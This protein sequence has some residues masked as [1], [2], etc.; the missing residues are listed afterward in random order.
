MTESSVAPQTDKI[1]HLDPDGGFN[2]TIDVC[3]NTR[4][5]GKPDKKDHALGEYNWKR[6]TIT[7]RRVMD[8]VAKGYGITAALGDAIKVSKSGK[9][10]GIHRDRSNFVS[11]QLAGVDFDAGTSFEDVLDYPLARNAGSFLY[12]TA[13]HTPEAPRCRLILCLEH[14]I[15]EPERAT[16]LLLALIHH[17]GAQMPDKGTHDCVRVW[18]GT[19]P[20]N[21]TYWIGEMLTMSQVDAL[22]AEYRAAGGIRTK[23]TQR[24]SNATAS[25]VAAAPATVAKARGWL[26]RLKPERADEYRDWLHVGMALQS[27]CGNA[28]LTLWEKWSEQSGQ[29]E[30][31]VCAAKWATFKPGREITLGTLML[32]AEADTP[33][34]HVNGNQA[35]NVIE[36]PADLPEVVVNNR[37]LADLY[38]ETMR[39]IEARNAANPRHPV[40]F[41][42]YGVPVRVGKD[43]DGRPRITDATTPAVRHVLIDTARWVKVEENT[44]TGATKTINVYPPRDLAETIV[45]A[46]EW[47]LPPLAGAISH[48]VY[49]IDWQLQIEQGYDARTR[50]HLDADWTGI[51]DIEPTPRNVARALQI[52]QHE[53]LTDFPFVDQ[54]SQAHALGLL[55]LPIVRPAIDGPTPG[56]LVKSPTPGTGKGLFVEATTR[57]FHPYGLASSQ[58]TNNEE[59]TRKLL[60]S[61]LRSG[62]PCAFFDNVNVSVSSAALAAAMTQAVWSDRLLGRNEDVTIPISTA[63]ILTANNPTL[64]SEMVRRCVLI[65]LDA[66][67][68]DPSQRVGFKHDPLIDW[69]KG[70]AREIV[71]SAIVLVEHWKA[72][73]RPAFKGRPKG[74]FEAWTRTIGGILQAAGIDGFLENEIELRES[75][76]NE[77]Q[78]LT[79]FCQRMY[80]VHG[81]EWCKASALMPIAYGDDNNDGLLLDVLTANTEQGRL[82]Q[83]AKWLTSLKD[84][85]VDIAERPDAEDGAPPAPPT[86]E[87][88]VKL[89]VQ[90]KGKR[91]NVFKLELPTM[92]LG[93]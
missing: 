42:R 75:T 79:A 58:I 50:L 31:G 76:R 25:I 85:M 4:W 24:D 82:V 2:P 49:S 18:Y 5:R 32:M 39:L 37:Q 30:N 62:R 51:G 65:H 9:S 74:S 46:G 54:A 90:S 36:T 78:T 35:F 48:P 45:S 40:L 43:E 16:E 11:L 21:Q 89:K 56:H 68:P 1:N 3:Y 26:A 44:K 73:G 34:V 91:G 47:N 83:L 33:L 84:R 59:E 12:T 93:L 7:T 88:L 13:S 28:G 55:L 66:D 63:W 72:N 80:E 29:F 22:I 69:I 92:M 27:G 53:L 20:G 86:P 57:P 8:A 14:P 38:T 60:T 10:R 61:I 64:S 67:M 87:L 41:V 70:N 77:A 19:V 52:L 6:I 71:W 81:A 15:T 23:P 17:F